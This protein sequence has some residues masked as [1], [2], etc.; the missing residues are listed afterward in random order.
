MN[1]L[2]LLIVFVFFGTL[3]ISCNDELSER[4]T[5]P[6]KNN[7][8][9][10]KLNEFEINQNSIVAERISKIE[11]FKSEIFTNKIVYDSIYDFF[12][13]TDE[14]LYIN[15]GISESFTFPV[16]RNSSNTILE[17]L[18]IHI[19]NQE[20]LVYL[21]NYGHSYNELLNMTKSQ[22][23]QND[24][25]HYL[26]D[27]NPSSILTGKLD[28]PTKEHICIETYVWDPSVPCNQGDNVGGAELFC[29]GYVL[30][31]SVCEWV[32]SG[33]G[34]TDSSS[35]STG[36]T[37]GTG[38]TGSGPTGGSTSTGSNT[39]SGTVINTT[40]IPCT[41]CI[42]F[43]ETLGGFLI[44]LNSN[45]YAFWNNLT[46]NEQQNIINYLEQPSADSNII[47]SLMDLMMTENIEFANF[48]QIGYT[49]FDNVSEINDHFLFEEI[50]T[51]ISISNNFDPDKKITVRTVRLNPFI[52]LV[53]ELV[54]TPN[55]NF[56]LDVDNSTSDID[57]IL[58]GNSWV[59]NSIIVTNSN[60]N[61][62]PDI[63][64]ITITGYILT[65]IKIGDYQTGL[66]K[67]K[68]IIIRVNKNTGYIFYSE[69]KNVN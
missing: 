61:G 49:S 56:S 24:V 44:S 41:S 16:Y 11:K 6:N 23:E 9:I 8:Q 63:A 10:R 39:S 43:N 40:Y 29:G 50:D 13:N 4:E 67:R 18:V 15:D 57:T 64:E 32:T 2:K 27:L 22:L 60:Y 52:D 53:I 54:I 38:T 21:V 30:Q 66:K 68:Q 47:L 42:D 28:A 69:V 33:G 25:K 45:Q 58:P 14:A 35:G 12:L 37:T 36:S 7:L 65:G 62:D 20:T 48:N 34:G 31:S 19:Q 5:Q 46:Q 59:Q 51:S 55:P 1:K 17:N 26:I 3:F